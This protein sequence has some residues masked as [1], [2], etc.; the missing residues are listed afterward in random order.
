MP[1]LPRRRKSGPAARSALPSLPFAQAQDCRLENGL[2]LLLNPSPELPLV[3]VQLWIQA[4]SLHEDPYLGSGIAHALEHMLFKGTKSRR[5]REISTEVS[6]LGGSINAYTSWNRTVY[7]IDGLAKH[8]EGY[9]AILSDMA[10]HSVLSAAEFKREQEVILREM[11]MDADDP[12]A[13]LQHAVFEALFR[14]HPL[15]HSILG[16]ATVFKALRT[17]DL[18]AFMQRHYRPNNAF[19]SV[20]GATD[21]VSLR[22]LA[23]RHFGHWKPG[24]QP[25]LSLPQPSTI[26]QSRSIFKPFDTAQSRLSL[27]WQVPGESSEQKVAL[28]V[29]SFLLG[30]GRSSRLHQRLVEVEACAHSV[31]AGCYGIQDHAILSLEAQA[32][33]QKLEACRSALHGE[34]QLLQRKGPGPSE[35]ARAIASAEAGQWRSLI[36]TRGQASALGSSWLACGHLQR[37]AQYLEQLRALSPRVLRE[38]ACSLLPLERMTEIAVGP[39]P[40]TRVQSGS[41]A[42]PSESRPL[43]TTLPNG[44]GLEVRRDDRVNLV[45]IRVC[46]LASLPVEPANLQGITML[47]AAL[48]L[49]GTAKRNALQ[50]AKSLEDRGGSLVCVADAQRLVL[51]ADVLAADVEVALALLAEL[52]TSAKLP[53]SEVEPLRQRQIARIQE[54]SEDPLSL[55]LRKARSLLLA[56]TCYANTAMGSAASLA[57]VSRGAVKKLLQRVLCGINAQMAVV[58]AISP[59]VVERLVR[60]HWS[61]L[62]R[63]QK[64]EAVWHRGAV[65]KIGQHEERLQKQQAVCI[66]AHAT[67][68]IGHKD[69]PALLILEEA[70]SDMGS[71]LF[72]RIR[73]QRGLAYSVGAQHMALLGTGAFFFYAVTSQEQWV[74]AGRELDATLDE[75]AKSG[76]SSAELLQA[77]ASWLAQWLRGQQSPAGRA[78][79]LAWAKLSGQGVAALEQLPKAVEALG[80]EDIRR[81]AKRYLKASSALRLR[82]CD[83]GRGRSCA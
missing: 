79:A 28:D 31:W 73:E 8:L 44:I 10:Q 11:A 59:E 12:D 5:A 36:S 62:P 23:Q 3:S 70:L 54:E 67:A 33:P 61:S 22:A 50:I 72:E 14:G 74:E 42:S 25:L 53:Q 40:Q 83:E 78:D 20:A 1:T 56:N 76:L 63:G 48:M 58:G 18:R 81:A 66:R 35:L 32:D 82:V 71:R 6:R 38:V 49:K 77:K 52:A 16:E 34:L 2:G 75:I 45:S 57:A 51:G 13:Q 19:L 43:S 29:I 30:S 27:N 41:L 7:W 46:F 37:G 21:M 60:R 69:L 17:S 47:S 80:L 24:P 55:G 65:V 26:L 64:P 9:L 39:A 15:Q 4:G 68:G